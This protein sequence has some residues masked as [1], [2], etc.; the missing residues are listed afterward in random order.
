MISNSK[1]NKS[2]GA[3]IEK[4]NE[5]SVNA[6]KAGDRLN[7]ILDYAGIKKGR[8]RIRLFHHYI[9]DAFEEH[10][11]LYDIPYTTVQSWF[12]DVAP[13][14]S[15]INPIIDNLHD[16]SQFSV[17]V[18]QIKLW[19]KMGGDSPF[20]P[21]TLSKEKQLK[22]DI[23][24]NYFIRESCGDDFENVDAEQLELIAQSVQSMAIDY[25]NPDSIDMPKNLIK[26]IVEDKVKKLKE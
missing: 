20:Q 11:G 26:L 21:G 9:L 1:T 10:A 17:D 16:H 5:E 8:G 3:F 25:A 22:L 6:L 15:K 7:T 24:I 2:N 19:W 23:E 4:A 13:P 14:F 12:G 18:D